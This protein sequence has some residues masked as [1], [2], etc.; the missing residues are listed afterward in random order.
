M[1][2]KRLTIEDLKKVREKFQQQ[3]TVRSGIARARLIVH[4]GTCGIAAG[5]REIL[6]AAMNLLEESKADD[7][8]ITTSSCAGLCSAEPM[9]TVEI[10]HQPP[11]KYI[12]LTPEKMER[13][14]KEHI[15]G[16]KIVKEFAL[17]TGSETTA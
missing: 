1:E 7:V 5:A 8:I 11:V 17:A 9:A 12:N 10:L 6:S 13:I 2:K 3:I 16:N 15:L 14:F 4:M